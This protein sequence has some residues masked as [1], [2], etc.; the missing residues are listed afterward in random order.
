MKKKLSILSAAVLAA[1]QHLTFPVR[2]E[3]V[4]ETFVYGGLEYTVDSDQ[5]VRLTGVADNTLTEVSIPAVIDGRAVT[6]DN[7][8]FS[9]CKDLV[10]I[11]VDTDSQTLESKDGVLFS[12]GGDVLIAYP[13]GRAGEYAVPEGTAVIEEY[14][15]EGAAGL[16]YVSIPDSL[17][18]VNPNAFKNCTSLTGFSQGLPM[19]YGT[20]LDGCTALTSVIVSGNDRSITTAG[21]R[22]KDC[23]ALESVVIDSSVELI[24]TFTI[25]NCPVLKKLEFPCTSGEVRIVINGCDSLESVKL[26]AS[27]SGTAQGS[28]LGISHCSSIKE[29]Y[30]SDFSNFNTAN[31]ESLETVR[32]GDAKIS[33]APKGYIFDH[34]SCPALK[35]VYYY[36]EAASIDSA[37]AVKFAEKGITV[38]IRKSASRLPEFLDHYKAE[39]VFI[40]DELLYGDANF[41]GNVDMSDVVTIM[42]SLA[43]PDRYR[44]N[45][46]QLL[47]G[48]VES[49]GN[50]ITIMDAQM[51]QQFLL[52]LVKN[53]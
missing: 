12:K 19:T 22:F 1:G 38:H 47:N 41:D 53:L 5:L 20:A 18:Q 43:A 35:D 29:L 13:A 8:P 9:D 50:G 10:S 48:D 7:S 23:Q 21:V 17:I 39:Y 31:M 15:F 14:S 36:D 34:E 51:I 30:I 16:T 46:A 11:N 42:Q 2:A 24:G 52:E 45:K 3:N 25:Q 6:V 33:G 27:E 4:P 37:D 26:P 49:K 44:L 32:F 40:E 28:T